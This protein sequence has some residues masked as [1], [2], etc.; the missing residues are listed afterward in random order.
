MQISVQNIL[1]FTSIAYSFIVVS[2]EPHI[3]KVQVS[4]QQK[5]GSAKYFIAGVE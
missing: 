3:V 5:L 2:L 1:I 4:H